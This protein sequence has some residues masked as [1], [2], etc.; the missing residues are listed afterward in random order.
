MASHCDIASNNSDRSVVKY[1]ET[2]KLLLGV[3]TQFKQGVSKKQR[4]Y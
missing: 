3:L 1:R 4:K 2:D